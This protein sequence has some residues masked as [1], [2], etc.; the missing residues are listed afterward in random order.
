[1]IP[2]HGSRGRMNASGNSSVLVPSFVPQKNITTSH[3]ATSAWSMAPI[4]LS[5]PA[6]SAG[7]SSHG[8]FGYLL[9]S[10]QYIPCEVVSGYR[11][12]R[13]DTTWD[14]I[15][16]IGGVSAVAVLWQSSRNILAVF[17]QYSG[18]TLEDIWKSIWQFFWSCS[19]R[20][21]CMNYSYCFL[22]SPLCIDLFP[23]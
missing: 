5:C 23:G 4:Y 18:P 21:S 1:M 20:L 14:R 2:L 3:K 13:R 22:Q 7:A 8:F 15:C 19:R 12:E 11:R 10:R 17:W 6:C 9:R 16:L